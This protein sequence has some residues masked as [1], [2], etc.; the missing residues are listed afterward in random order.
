MTFDF[1]GRPTWQFLRDET[2]AVIR[3]RINRWRWRTLRNSVTGGVRYERGPLT[4]QWEHGAGQ[5]K[6]GRLL[7][8]HCASKHPYRWL[9]IWRTNDYPV[10]HGSLQCPD[11]YP[12]PM[13]D[14]SQA[15][16]R[17]TTP[18][19]LVRLRA[20]PGV[21]MSEL[22]APR[23]TGKW[24]RAD[25]PHTGWRSIEINDSGSM[26]EMCEVTPIT[27]AHIMQHE[28]YPLPL[29][30]GCVCAGYMTDDPAAEQLREVIYKWRR[31]QLLHR[32]PIEKLRRQG[33]STTR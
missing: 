23:Q 26:C 16:A 20:L 9:L 3:E 5:V 14:R 33:W 29:E 10:W 25:I 27:Y 19:F 2:G 12:M 22:G 11:K 13:D 28:H 30:C 8:V 31:L 24:L 15:A 4:I 17:R 1:S 21:D 32:T 7:F 18:V 6:L